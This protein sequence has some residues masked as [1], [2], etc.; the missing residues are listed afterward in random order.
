M[1]IPLR[2]LDQQWQKLTD[3][4]LTLATPHLGEAGA[5]QLASTCRD[6]EALPGT[7]ELASQLR[8]AR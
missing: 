3:K 5:R 4:F 6:L 2:D 1:A 7:A 8:A